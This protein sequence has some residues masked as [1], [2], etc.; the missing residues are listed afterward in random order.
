MF[1][2]GLDT[3]G[4]QLAIVTELAQ[5]I[6]VVFEVALQFLALDQLLTDLTSTG[7]LNG[8]SGDG[9]KTVGHTVAEGVDLTHLKVVGLDF[10]AMFGLTFD[11]LGQDG[12][13][14]FGGGEGS[15]FVLSVLVCRD[16][17]RERHA[18]LA[19]TAGSSNAVCVGFGG[20]GEVKVQDAG[21]VLEVDTT[22]DTIVLFFRGKLA[23]LIGTIRLLV[24]FSLF[25]IT[26]A[27][28]TSSFLLLIGTGILGLLRLRSEDFLV[29]CSN[30]DVVNTL[31]ELL[32]D[33]DSGVH[34]QLRVE[35]TALDAE[36]FQEKLEAIATVDVSDE[37]DDFA[38]DELKLENNICQEEF[39]IL[40]ASDER[41][42]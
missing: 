29:I 28:D 35:H 4:A 23:A 33:V 37:Y 24:V 30:D 38:L 14:M 42:S 40:C 3:C 27:H 6:G 17:E 21:H 26:R 18:G 31:V 5:L 2:V 10:V 22:R 7:F 41:N 13:I 8:K 36:L 9:A 15:G 11:D 16:D 32:D 1:E 12:F 25:V 39:L 34:W 19:A 20:C